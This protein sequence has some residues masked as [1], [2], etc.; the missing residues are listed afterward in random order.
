MANVDPITFEVIRNAL[1]TTAAEM[2][3]VVMRSSYSTIWRESGDL[4]C[5]ILSRDGEM[6][7]AASL[8]AR[9]P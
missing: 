9:K 3:V 1:L 5:A 4:S 6:I 2:K 7:P 8:S